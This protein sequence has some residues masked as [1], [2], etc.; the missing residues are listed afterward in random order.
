M[1]PTWKWSLPYKNLSFTNDNTCKCLTPCVLYL[2]W[3]VDSVCPWSTYVW[4]I[5]KG[6]KDRKEV[7]RRTWVLEGWW[8]P[9]FS[10]MTST[11]HRASTSINKKMDSMFPSQSCWKDESGVTLKT[12]NGTVI[13]WPAGDSGTKLGTEAR[14]LQGH[15]SA[16]VLT[17]TL[18]IRFLSREDI[19]WNVCFGFL[20]FHLQ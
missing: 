5:M 13:Q 11:S 2:L 16:W 15:M 4:S 14:I 3:I 9:C 1:K 19:L 6:E 7:V 12:E 20:W 8:S 18:E 17:V 10:L